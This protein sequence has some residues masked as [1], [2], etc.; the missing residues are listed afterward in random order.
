MRVI[1]P[2][3]ALAAIAVAW[4]IS[5]RVA[6]GQASEERRRMEKWNSL[7]VEER[8]AAHTTWSEQRVTNDAVDKRNVWTFM[9]AAACGGAL[10][11]AALQDNTDAVSRQAEQAESQTR[12]NCLAFRLLVAGLTDATDSDIRAMQQRRDRLADALGNRD[13]QFSSIPGYEQ[14]GPAVKNF[15]RGLV[16]GQVDDT[17][18]EIARLD[19]DLAR[20][21]TNEDRLSEFATTLNCPE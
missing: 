19:G 6:K 5:D 9:V 8:L 4:L 16:E 11:V 7:S 14:L 17:Q 20:L 21:R 15:L 2:I 10:L 18:D 3:L 1:W 12:Q 13:T